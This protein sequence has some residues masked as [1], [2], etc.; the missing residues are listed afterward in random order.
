MQTK[1][2]A[3]LLDNLII[4]A[5]CQVPW[6]SMQGTDR[7]RDCSQCSRQVYNISDMSRREAEAF[8][9]QHGT[10]HCTTFYRRA[11]GTIMTD[12]CPVGLRKLR[13]RYRALV[14][15]AGGIIAFVVA[16]P[17][18]IAQS[19][20]DS[21]SPLGSTT[22]QAQTAQSRGTVRF[23]TAGMPS[24]LGKVAGGKKQPAQDAGLRTVGDIMFFPPVD[25][26][27]QTAQPVQMLGRMPRRTITLIDDKPIVQEIVYT[28]GK[29]GLPDDDAVFGS[30]L[31]RLRAEKTAGPDSRAYQQYLQ[32]IENEDKG[33]QLV[34]ATYYKDALRTMTQSALDNLNDN[35]SAYDPRLKQAIEEHLHRL[36]SLLGSPY[37]TSTP[38]DDASATP[39]T[40]G[41]TEQPN[42]TNTV[43]SKTIVPDDAAPSDTSD[44][45]D[46]N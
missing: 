20:S 41:P 27:T 31:I 39:G 21:S 22:H 16:L 18:A 43:G 36:Q 9:A 4:A 40:A 37:Y 28:R 17:A 6:T 34:A 24:V 8:L 7:V 13:D 1:D 25:S 44:T 2:T 12:D 42:I 32:A 46:E 29:N 5:P 33:R 26:K 19:R 3:S 10:S 38:S 35:Q 14:R 15:I 30:G 11:D 23:S 45:S